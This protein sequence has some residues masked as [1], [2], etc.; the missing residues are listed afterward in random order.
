VGRRGLLAA[1][2]CGLLIAGCGGDDDTS[3][4]PTFAGSDEEQVAGTVN[5]MT[6]AI[7]AG[8]GTTACALMTEKGQRAMVRFGGQ[9]LGAEAVD[10][11]EEAVPAAADAG[12]DPGDFRMTVRDVSFGPKADEAWANCEFRGGFQLLRTEA[13]WRVN[14]P[15]CFD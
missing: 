3:E 14:I 6:A 12:Y 7:A 1:L 10:S 4:A 11:C 8:D 9:V 15:Y 5:A 2:G 13:G